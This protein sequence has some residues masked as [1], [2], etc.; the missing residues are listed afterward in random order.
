M[1]P[2]AYLIT[3][4]NGHTVLQAGEDVEE[5][6]S[7]SVLR[8]FATR[9]DLGGGAFELTSTEDGRTRRYEPVTEKPS[10]A[11]RFRELVSDDGLDWQN[12]GIV[13]SSQA[14]RRCAR[15]VDRGL[16]RLYYLTDGTMVLLEHSK[17]APRQLL[18]YQPVVS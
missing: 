13:P 5:Q 6:T 18:R 17:A 7:F 4:A 3:Y 1:H 10:R 9:R 2:I 16:A 11:L 14:A 15:Q 8:G 12:L